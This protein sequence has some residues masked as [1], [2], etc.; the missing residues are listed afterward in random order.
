MIKRLVILLHLSVLL[1]SACNDKDELSGKTFDVSLVSSPNNLD[2]RIYELKDDKLVMQFENDNETLEI[3]FIIE[4]SDKE[5][6]EYSGE[7]SDSDFQIEDSKRISKYNEFYL[8]LPDSPV[9][10]IER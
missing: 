3:E 5:F 4:E 1:L 9:E 7:I 8:N 6:S 2:E 10:F